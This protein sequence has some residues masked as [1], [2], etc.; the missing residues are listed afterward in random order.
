MIVMFD[1]KKPNSSLA[2]DHRGENVNKI[3]SG[4]HH[5]FILLFLRHRRARYPWLPGLVLA[6]REEASGVER[7]S[8]VESENLI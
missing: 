1:I 6:R 7:R 8:D 2:F 5:N 3:C 4:F